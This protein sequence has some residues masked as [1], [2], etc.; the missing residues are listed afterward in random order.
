MVKD[1]EGTWWENLWKG[2]LENRYVNGPFW[3]APHLRIFLSYM[4][5]TI[6]NCDEMSLLSGRQDYFFPQWS[7]TWFM[8]HWVHK[9]SG[10]DDKG[11]SSVWAQ[12][13][14]LSLR[15][16]WLSWM[17]ASLPIL[18]LMKSLWYGT[19]GRAAFLVIYWSHW[20]PSSLENGML[21]FLE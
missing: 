16:I 5:E 21:S 2:D 9:W 10:L 15:L 3:V 18:G 13:T 4:T 7:H 1:W 12:W 11:E 8:N 19:M 20:T 17:N 14:F 6:K